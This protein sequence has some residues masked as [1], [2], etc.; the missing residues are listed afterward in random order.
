MKLTYK[1]VDGNLTYDVTE[2]IM[3]STIAFD[4]DGKLTVA[5]V[6]R[7]RYF[8]INGTAVKEDSQP[9]QVVDIAKLRDEVLTPTV[10]SVEQITTALLLRFLQALPVMTGVQ[11]LVLPTLP[12]DIGLAVDAAKEDLLSHSNQVADINTQ[13]DEAD[14][15]LGLI[16]SKVTSA[17]SNLTYLEG[18]L[19]SMAAAGD[20]AKLALDAEIQVLEAKKNSYTDTLATLEQAIKDLSD[21]S[22]TLQMQVA[23]LTAAAAAATPTES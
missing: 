19:K 8:S 3:A 10:L 16:Q 1:L 12:D 23:Q 14:A 13:I 9:A 2:V 15:E 4:S 5:Q 6:V 22:T 7:R 20:S 18:G 17:Q 11:D 21:K